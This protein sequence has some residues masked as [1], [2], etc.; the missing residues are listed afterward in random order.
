LLSV[1]FADILQAAPFLKHRPQ[2][3]QADSAY[4]ITCTEPLIG[5]GFWLEVGFKDW[6]RWSRSIWGRPSCCQK[7][8]LLVLWEMDAVDT[9]GCSYFGHP[10]ECWHFGPAQSWF[11][12]VLAQRLIFCCSYLSN[13]YSRVSSMA[14][15]FW[16]CYSFICAIVRYF[17]WSVSNLAN[18]WAVSSSCSFRDLLE[19]ILRASSSLP[20]MAL[21]FLLRQFAVLSINL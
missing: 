17:S 10:E 9:S 15:L 5:V 20:V 1:Y 19:N 6:Q 8:L 18:L 7:G 12:D 14:I 2:N 16:L 4:S 11:F 3:C 13:S 21:V